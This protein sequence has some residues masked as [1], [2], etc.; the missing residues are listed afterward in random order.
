MPF[1]AQWWER[2]SRGAPSAA[3]PAAAAVAAAAV[4]VEAAEVG[5]GS[6]VGEVAPVDRP[7]SLASGLESAGSVRECRPE[8]VAG[9]LAEVAGPGVAAEAETGPERG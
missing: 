5:S 9:G 2:P 1:D 8:M 7:S 6:G 3:G 4:A